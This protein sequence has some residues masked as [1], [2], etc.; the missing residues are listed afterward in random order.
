MAYVS[1]ELKMELSPK[2]KAVL[3]KYGVKGTLSVVHHS[4][5]RLKI[6][7]SHYN[8]MQQVA[9]TS[10]WWSEKETDELPT[11]HSINTFHFKT[12]FTGELVEFLTEIHEAMNEGNFDKSD[13]QSDYFHVG[14]Y[15]SIEFGTWDKPYIYTPKPESSKPSPSAPVSG[16]S[17]EKHV[18]TKKGFDMHIVILSDRV[19]KSEFMRLL[20][21]AKESYGWYSRKWGST[22]AGFAFKEEQAAI[23]FAAQ[24]QSEQ[25]E[26]IEISSE[27]K[28]DTRTAE[29]LLEMADKMQK[30]IDD[31]MADRL[32]NT[33]KRARQAA[34]AVLQGRH[35][36]RA[37]SAIRAV[38]AHY[39]AGTVPAVIA[40]VKSKKAFLEH[41]KTKVNYSGG[42]YDAGVCTG[43]PYSD[44]P[45]TLEMFKLLS[46]PTDAEKKADEIN[47][48]I[49]E[50]QFSSI[51]GYFP[52][53]ETVIDLMT[54]YAAIPKDQDLMILEPEAGSGAITDYVSQHYPKASID[55]FEVNNSLRK[56]LKAKGVNLIG[57]DFMEYEP[58]AIYDYVLMNPPFE[59]L[60]DA[61]HVQQAFKY[62]KEGGR[63]VS[64]MSPSVFFRSDKKSEAFREWFELNNGE[65]YDLPEGSFKNSGTNV[66]T[67]IIVMEKK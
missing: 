32:T 48:L 21:L 5:L 2:I 42:Y 44:D 34:E 13:S 26:A 8:V 1:Q 38:A 3:K 17:I 47:A 11:N 4:K 35:F 27:P 45:K 10:Q 39:E 40:G 54:D 16:A 22:P 37:Q 59:L 64:V 25:P 15:T 31:K 57:Q 9:D 43:E 52:T 65:K 53:P 24:I 58:A 67:V 33:P 46:G 60:Q 12:Q 18:H 19:E 66:S 63:L 7:E 51:A 56:V 62:L 50:L 55:A 30:S 20:G 49:R 6:I 36:K 41:T 61:A 28:P 23:E 29:K 14:W